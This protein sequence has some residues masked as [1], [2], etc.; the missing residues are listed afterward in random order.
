MKSCLQYLVAP[1]KHPGC[2]ECGELEPEK[3]VESLSQPGE[4]S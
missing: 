1:D 4:L 2:K 3:M